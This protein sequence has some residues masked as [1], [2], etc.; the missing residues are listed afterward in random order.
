MQQYGFREKHSTEF[1]ALILVDHLTYKLN[2]GQILLN[3]YIQT[4]YLKLLAHE[5]TIF[6]FKKSTITE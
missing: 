5:F 2:N 3:V 6:F 1:V 4:I